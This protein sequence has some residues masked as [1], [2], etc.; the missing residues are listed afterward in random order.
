MKKIIKR[1]SNKISENIV[2]DLKLYV[3]ELQAENEKLREQVNTSNGVVSD[4]VDLIYDLENLDWGDW[5][6]EGYGNLKYIIKQYK[7]KYEDND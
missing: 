3:E 2:S 7:G 6:D 5:G 1:K 4:Y